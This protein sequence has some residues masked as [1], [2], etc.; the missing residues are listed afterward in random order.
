MPGP[1]IRVVLV[2]GDTSIRRQLWER[3]A[4]TDDMR[5]IAEVKSKDPVFE[6]IAQHQPDVIVL[7]A[8]MA[9]NK[10]IELIQL[11]RARAFSA[12]ILVQLLS[13]DVLAI[14]A[15]IDAGANG[16]ALQ[17]SPVEEVID[18]IRAV[19]EANQVV[20]QVRRCTWN[21][22]SAPRAHHNLP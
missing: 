4:Q 17:F 14:R 21:D 16:Y 20:V 15:A 10:Q 19:Q 2:D 3:F 18:A 13:E 22:H 7:D 5:L 11:F 9:N 8:H 1:T 12:G 6:L